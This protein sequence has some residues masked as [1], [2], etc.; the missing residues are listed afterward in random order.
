MRMLLAPLF[1]LAL[2]AAAPA[3]AAVTVTCPTPLA[4]M[5]SR[6]EA[7]SCSEGSRSRG[8][9]QFG[10]RIPYAGCGFRRIFPHRLE[11]YGTD[12]LVGAIARVAA[13]LQRGRFRHTLP[14]GVQPPL[15]VG[16]L[17]PPEGL[18]RD[19]DPFLGKRFSMSHASG[20][21]VDLAFFILDRRGRS[22]R[23]HE[24]AIGYR[25]SGWN[26]SGWRRI[27]QLPH[28]GPPFGCQRGKSAGGITEWKCFVPAGIYRLDDERNWA[29]VRAF[30]LDPVVGVIDPRTRR[31]RPAHRGV[32][33]MLVAN[34]IQA[35]ILAQARREGEPERLVELARA[36][37][38]QPSNAPPHDDH[39]HVDLNCEH[40][41]IATC[42][43]R[44]EGVPPRPYVGQVIRVKPR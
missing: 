5:K 15:G 21:S 30:L 2:L 26:Q 39:L 14:G 44:N 40:A 9:L 42:G 33:R 8:T 25:I 28:E 35:R 12:E 34:G 23:P 1:A 38:R 3:R 22:V 16:N 20:R 4:E 43:C 10:A 37:M 6:P 41:D 24:T 7:P 31:V 11:D 13:V 36:V 18:E 17:A 29:L 27:Y 32:R 19:P